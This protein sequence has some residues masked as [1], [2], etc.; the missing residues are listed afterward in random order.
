MKVHVVQ[1]FMEFADDEIGT[2][3]GQIIGVYNDEK[4]AKYIA[5]KVEKKEPIPGINYDNLIDYDE[6]EIITFELNETIT[7]S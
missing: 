2:R 4:V 6:V 5:K 7:N 1:T 3:G